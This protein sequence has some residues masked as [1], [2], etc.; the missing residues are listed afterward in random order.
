MPFLC[1]SIGCGNR[2]DESGTLAGV[3]NLNVQLEQL[4]AMRAHVGPQ[5]SPAQVQGFVTQAARMVRELNERVQ[6][7]NEN[8]RTQFD[9]LRVNLLAVR[10]RE[11]HYRVEP[12][13]APPQGV[14][15]TC[16][17]QQRFEKKLFELR[18]NPKVCSD[19]RP[20][21]GIT[22]TDRIEMEY[23]C[24][25][26]PDYVRELLC[27][28]KALSAFFK[29]AL[30]SGCNVD[31]FVQFPKTAS[32]L[33]KCHADKRFG[34]VFGH[35]P[36][37]PGI[38]VEEGK[39]MMKVRGGIAGIGSIEESSY[40]PVHDCK[41]RIALPSLVTRELLPDSPDLEARAVAPY[42]V[43][44]GEIFR[45]LKAKTTGYE[46]VEV[47]AGGLSSWNTIQCGSYNPELGQIEQIDPTKWMDAPPVAFVTL[48]EIRARFPGQD[49]AV[50]GVKFGICISRQFEDT[51]NGPRVDNTH[52]FMSV[53]IPQD[54]GRYRELNLGLQPDFLP[55]GF[56]HKLWLIGSTELAKVHLIDESRY[57]IGDMQE[58]GLRAHRGVIYNLSAEER[59]ILNQFVAR[60]MQKGFDGKKTFT[61]QGNNCAN[62]LQKVFWELFVKP[63]LFNQLRA[64]AA[65]H[66]NQN[67]PA[68]INAVERATKASNDKALETHVT[69]VI[70]NLDREQL[71]SVIEGCH[72]L[73][74]RTLFKENPDHIQAPDSARLRRVDF[75][76]LSKETQ[77]LLIAT[78]KS[79][80]FFRMR[81][82]DT[83]ASLGIF[84]WINRG[85]NWLIEK[86]IAS[87][88]AVSVFYQVINFVFFG[89]WRFSIFSTENG[90]RFKSLFTSKYH[91]AGTFPLPSAFRGW[92]KR[93]LFVRRELSQRIQRINRLPLGRR[94]SVA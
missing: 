69:K 1:F 5:F 23:V 61:I 6:T 22:E 74:S 65:G 72:S 92:E 9:R 53:F 17:D 54:D 39:V 73:L 11:S 62:W 51:E 3:K 60:E 76:S 14:P 63:Y 45:Q 86:N 52:T 75:I 18:C 67:L 79:T 80:Q 25:Q 64:I 37:D 71:I 29:W 28:E 2:V 4:E 49:V 36:Q 89:S 66:R 58:G 32:D 8:E 46:N 34:A 12:G 93:A 81:I 47:L 87:E 31:V 57:L 83:D 78:L 35:N 41:L 15:L 30:R 77:S 38:R 90:V 91:Q 13:E 20:R 43:T 19:D 42:I 50:E 68:Y 56:M 7:L 85:F 16:E 48:D 59:G 26:Y 21:D 27:N 33:M 70:Q 82:R 24:R 40:V 44:V 55:K 88:K 10:A 84:N 94:S